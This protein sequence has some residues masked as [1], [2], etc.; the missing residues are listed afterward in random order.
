VGVVRVIML[1]FPGAL[2]YSPNTFAPE[3]DAVENQGTNL[4]TSEH[5]CSE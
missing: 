3:E 2:M 1:T 4:D 5:L